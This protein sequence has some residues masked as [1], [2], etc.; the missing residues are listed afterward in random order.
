MVFD[1]CSWRTFICWPIKYCKGDV[2]AAARLM[3]DIDDDTPG[4]AA[5]LK[6]L[7]PYTGHAHI[8]GFTGAPGAGKSTL[9]DG[10]VQCLRQQGKTVGVLAIDPTSPYSGGAFLGDRIRMQRHANDNSCIYKKH[11]HPWPHRRSLTIRFWHNNDHG[12]HGQ[13][14]GPRRNGRGRPG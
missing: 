12:C 9:M 6:H 8:I 14:C 4:A 10:M 3:R 7:Y 11:C 2:K 5:H 1:N 13:G